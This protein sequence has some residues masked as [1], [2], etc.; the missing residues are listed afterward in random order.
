MTV[1]TNCM[2]LKCV[3]HSSSTEKCLLPLT[4]FLKLKEMSNLLL[5]CVY[6]QMCTLTMVCVCGVREPLSWSSSLLSPWV[7]GIQPKSSGLCIKCFQVLSDVT[8]LL[9]CFFIKT[10]FRVCVC[11]YVCTCTHACTCKWFNVPSTLLS[12]CLLTAQMACLLFFVGILILYAANVFH[13][14]FQGTEDSLYPT[15]ACFLF[16]FLLLLTTIL[17]SNLLLFHP[18][19]L[20][21]LSLVYLDFAL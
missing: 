9:E 2:S 20:I 4:S 14:V 11:V 19:L 21:F 8:H 18:T 3:T 6:F 17:F 5:W 13:L 16:S 12:G 7:P 10:C 1:F 15:V